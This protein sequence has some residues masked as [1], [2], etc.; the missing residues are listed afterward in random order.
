MRHALFPPGKRIRP[1]LCIAAYHASLVRQSAHA[2]PSSPDILPFAAGI[3]LIHN[4]SLIQD[5]LPCMDNDMVRRGKP[6]LHVAFGEAV[7]LLAS[8]AMFSRAFEL[9]ADS[10]ASPVRKA[11]A[12]REVARAVGSQGIVEGQLKDIDRRKSKNAQALRRIHCQ[13]TARLIA[14]CYSVGAIIAG[15]G[16]PVI[17]GLGRAGMYLGMLFQITDDLLDEA[18]A[19]DTD[20]L[21]YPGFYG[22][23]GAQFRARSYGT[24]YESELARLGDR[25][26]PAGVRDL[27]E[28][29]TLVLMRNR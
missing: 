4:F 7:A 6:T 26:S 2:G 9:F 19:S 12:I 16:K 1:L 5:D 25:L 10:T 20:A 14:A 29:G 22:H 23:A 21:T 17:D 13:K 15:A 3:E 8:D 27:R 28:A 11:R 24:R 18:Q